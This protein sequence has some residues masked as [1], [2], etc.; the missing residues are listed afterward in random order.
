MLLLLIAD[1][2]PIGVDPN[3]SFDGT[4]PMAG[5]DD[6]GAT[7][8]PDEASTADALTAAAAPALAAAA[9]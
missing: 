7:S 9:N 6:A 3:A 5:A 2:N 8:D 1:G 4:Q